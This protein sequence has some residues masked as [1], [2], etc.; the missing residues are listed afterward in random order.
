MFK[1]SL[2]LSLYVEIKNITLR[3]SL[4]TLA[5]SALFSGEFRRNFEIGSNF[6]RLFYYFR[7]HISTSDFRRAFVQTYVRLIYPNLQ[8]IQ[9]P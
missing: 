9:N 6:F 3:V 1:R 4:N 8:K 2:C 5:L 7:C